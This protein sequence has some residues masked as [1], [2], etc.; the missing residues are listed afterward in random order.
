MHVVLIYCLESN[1]FWVLHLYHLQRRKNRDFDSHVTQTLRQSHLYFLFLFVYKYHRNL[2]NNSMLHCHMTRYWNRCILEFRR[3]QLMKAQ[4]RVSKSI[5]SDKGCKFLVKKIVR[6]KFFTKLTPWPD[7]FDQSFLFVEIE[8]FDIWI[9][10]F[11]TY[12]KLRQRVGRP[13][14]GRRR[15]MNE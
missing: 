2:T 9:E 14:K 3:M 6:T 7:V 8:M 11:E 13:N 12:P 5:E 10:N 4:L 15:Q 1:K